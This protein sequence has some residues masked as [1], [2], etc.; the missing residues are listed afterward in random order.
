MRLGRHAQINGGAWRSAISDELIKLF[1]T[2]LFGCASGKYD[3]D[4]IV[5]NLGIDVHLVYD[6]AG[7]DNILRSYHGIHL[8]NFGLGHAAHDFQ[9]F[10]AI[11]ITDR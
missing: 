8:R 3:I 6:T 11:R 7:I 2:V 5:F 10:V 4:D 1:Q 9:F